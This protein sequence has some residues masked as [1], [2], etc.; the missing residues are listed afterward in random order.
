M[1]FSMHANFKK[2]PKA[3][4]GENFKMYELN[5]WDSLCVDRN[6]RYQPCHR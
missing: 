6:D 4:K 5:I 3:S 1:Y 2:K